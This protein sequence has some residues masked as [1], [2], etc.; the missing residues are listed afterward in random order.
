MKWRAEKPPTPGSPFSWLG[1][2]WSVVMAAIMYGLYL[3]HDFR[4]LSEEQIMLFVFIVVPVAAF[5]L[6]GAGQ[7][8]SQNEADAAED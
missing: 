4:V 3:L 2:I 5:V 1:M 8:R 7:D 6:S